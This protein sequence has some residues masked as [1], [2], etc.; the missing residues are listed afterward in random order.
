MRPDALPRPSRVVTVAGVLLFVLSV[1]WFVLGLGHV[2]R[3]PALGWLPTPA[4]SVLA[5]YACWRAGRR[6]DLDASTRRFWRQM[7][8]ICGL[9]GIA[10]LSNMAD[11]LLGPGGPSQVLGARTLVL[12]FATLAIAMWAL[13]RLPTWGRSRADWIRFG[14]DSSIVLVTTTG[15]AWH[16]SFSKLSAWTAQTGSAMPLVAITALAAVSMITFAKVAF[17]GAGNL[18]RRAL[19]ILAGG[20][21]VSAISGAMS[22]FVADRPYI[23]TTF[24]AG[25]M[26]ALTCLLAAQRQERAPV[27]TAERPPRRRRFTVT[28]YLAITAMSAMLISVVAPHGGEDLA[29]AL[30]AVTLTGLVAVRQASALRDNNRLL[31]TVDANLRKLQDVQQELAHQVS[32]DPLTEIGNRAMFTAQLTS[33]LGAGERFHVVLVDLDDFKEVNDRL[34]HG[35]GDALLKAVSRRLHERLRPGDTVARLGGDEF[36]LLLRGRSDRETAALLTDLTEAVREPLLLDGHDLVARISAGVTAAEP[37]DTA[38][39]LM[40]RA[41]VAMYTAKSSGGGRWTWFDTIMDQL[42][43]ADARLGNDLR[44]ALARDQMFV[45]YQPIVEL[46]HGRLAGVEALVRWRHPEHGLVSPAVFIPLAERNGTIVELGRWILRQVVAQATEWERAY[47]L[48]APEKVSINISA[49]QLREPGFAAEVGELLRSS[50]I[51]PHRLVAEVTETAVLGTGEALD[52]VHELHKL[53]MR[54]ALDDFGT[55]QS[56][57]SLLVDTPVRVLK[58]DKSFVDGV[59]ARSSQ[60]VIVDGLIGITDGLRIEAVAE[61]VESADQAQR[62]YEVGYQYAQGFHFSRPMSA[63]DIGLLLGGVRAEISTISTD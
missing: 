7:A 45:L 13:L 59:T 15:L 47:G 12:Y 46:P 18:D 3:H 38:E 6:A 51:D 20:V 24:L 55:G 1:A 25:A 42:A 23:S 58:V 43:D 54:V 9:L 52:A 49:R 34:G 41:D 21:V 50:G 39:E 56:S 29:V 32:H 4:M 37:G 16:F 31:G 35:V 2:W 36:T 28:P 61:G 57:L 11:A 53:G 8:L 30:F 62:L 40:R 27:V 48:R 33:V 10:V 26:S 22:P 14:L 63:D 19:H 44:Q 17:A 5:T 60:A